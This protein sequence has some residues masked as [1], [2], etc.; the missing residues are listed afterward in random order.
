MPS[1]QACSL[2]CDGSGGKIDPCSVDAYYGHL[3]E[4]NKET[5]RVDQN[6][7]TLTLWVMREIK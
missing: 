2:R 5:G 3:E 4:E 1:F 6:I 7:I